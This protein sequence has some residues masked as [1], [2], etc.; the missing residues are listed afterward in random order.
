MQERKYYITFDNKEY[1][2]IEE[3]VAYLLD[4]DILY[5]GSSKDKTEATL[6]VNCN[7]YFIPAADGESI[8]YSEIQKLF[9]LVK[10]KG[11]IGVH[12]FVA[13]KRN[14]PNKH[15]REKESWFANK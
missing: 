10:E 13:K 2:V 3:M 12:E 8:A 11:E 7:D 1:A 15:W 6:Y 9:E 4:S 14:I 5:I